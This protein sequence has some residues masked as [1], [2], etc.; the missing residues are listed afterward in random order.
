MRPDELS[1]FLSPAL[2][3]PLTLEDQVMAGGDIVGGRL[4]T[5]SGES[6]PIVDGIPQLIHPKSLGASTAAT[7]AFYDGRSETYDQYL[8]LTFAVHNEDE[9]TLRNQFID[10]LDLKPESR[11]LEVAA[12]TGRDSEG[13]VN[14]LGPN[15]LLCVQDLS[16]GMLRK[17]K[18]RLA[19][20]KVPTSYS[21]AN[22]EYLP[23]AD[24]SFDA[25]YSFGGLGE[26]PDIK[27]CLKEMV[28]VCRPGGKIVVG[29][30]S[31][32]PWLRQT[33]FAKILATTNPQFFAPL[34]LDHMP[35][36]ARD[37]RL[38]WV[39]G[40]VFYLIDFRVGTGPPTA[41]FDFP[42]PGP[43]GGTLRT[44]Y[45]G[46]LEG[47]TPEAKRLAHAAREKAAVS[48]HDWLDRT[49]REAAARELGEREQ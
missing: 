5:T 48:M 9:Q 46:Q 23:F 3:E 47:V 10:S 14:R 45:E 32:P 27:R 18:S 6:Y 42:V 22:A 38:R 36:E 44:R 26:F 7:Q 30:E 1:L 11:V 35:E 21:L 43:R 40:G 16:E 12:G 20:A 49:V 19:G 2:Q 17:A 15:G 8:H 29:D 28:R 25:V 41:N 33:E 13:I 24:Q 31:I 37:V 34:P 4:V 39:I